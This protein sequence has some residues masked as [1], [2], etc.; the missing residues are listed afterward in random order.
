MYL[1]YLDD[2]GSAPNPNEEYFVLGGIAIYEAQADW[3]A[4]EM[5]RRATDVNN[6]NPQS[7]E[8]HASEIYSGRDAPWNAMSKENRR[9]VIKSVLRVVN[10]SYETARTFACAVHKA[11]YPGRDPVEMAFEDICSRFDRFLGRVRNEGHRERGIIIFDES[12][13]ETAIQRMAR[14]FRALGTRWGSI[15]NL[16]ETP[17][18]VDS[19]ASRLVQVAD[20]VAYAVFRRYNASDTQ[21]FDIFAQRF[22]AMNGVIH[23]LAHKQL[24]DPNCLCPAC[25][26]R[27]LGQPRENDDQQSLNIP[28]GP[29]GT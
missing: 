20:H 12:A 26:S 1:L 25:L 10:E 16:A 11:S 17:L 23:G 3:F 8:F 18:F 21:Y 13:H 5:D 4:R 24:V 22:D 9:G 29:A 14:D 6:S 2:A 15:R 28:D 27:R 7:V 19:R